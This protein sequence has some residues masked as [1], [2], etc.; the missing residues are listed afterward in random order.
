MRRKK[1]K[2]N[3]NEKK[4]LCKLKKLHTCFNRAKSGHHF[5]KISVLLEEKCQF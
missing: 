1:K 5:A 3:K 2:L 4:G